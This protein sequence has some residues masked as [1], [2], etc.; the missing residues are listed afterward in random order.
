MIARRSA[1]FSFAKPPTTGSRKLKIGVDDLGVDRRVDRH[2]LVGQRGL[3]R[4]VRLERLRAERR[5]Q[6]EHVELLLVEREPARLRLLH[7]V[8]LDAADLRDR[9]ARHRRRDPRVPRVAR[10]RLEVP[11]DLAETGIGDEHDLRRARPFGEHVGPGADRVRG[12]L[13]AVRGDDLARH[14]A[15]RRVRHHEG[16]VVVGPREPHAQRV[17]VDGL[18]VGQ[19]RVVVEPAAFLRRGRQRVEAADL[20]L[21][22]ERVR[23][24]VRRVEEPHERVDEVLRG[25]LARDALERRVGREQD[26]APQPERVGPAV[27]RHLGHRLGRHRHEARGAREIVVREEPV[28]DGLE[29]DRRIVV[30]H[31]D[32][33]EAGLGGV[34]R[35]AE[36]LRGVGGGHA[37]ADRTAASA[38]AT[39]RGRATAGTSARSARGRRR[40]VHHARPV[41]DRSRRVFPRLRTSDCPKT[42]SC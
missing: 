41:F 6:V 38:A 20:A 34:E 31:A 2:L 1:T 15:E 35:H 33:I 30:R 26:A 29:D 14:R 39:V 12:D 11:D 22:H 40:V 32:G 4:A 18:E 21:E 19:L 24:A 5:R 37:G 7:R 42:K 10:G 25:Q 13:A 23:R 16:K 3:E 9:L 17:A 8:D 36:D 27:V 28:E